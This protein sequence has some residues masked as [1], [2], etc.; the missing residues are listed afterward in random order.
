MDTRTGQIVK[1]KDLG[2]LQKLMQTNEILEAFIPKD[3]TLKQEETL[4]VSKYDNR[5]KPGKKF[6]ESR[7]VR[8]RK[9]REEA[10]RTN[11]K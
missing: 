4:Q 5:S 3:M 1:S 8:R 9:E 7:Q 10:K 6:K 2:E 11:S